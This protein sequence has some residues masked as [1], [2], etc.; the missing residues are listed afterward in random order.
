MF[1]CWC[2]LASQMLNNIT[3]RSPQQACLIHCDAWRDTHGMQVASVPEA[4]RETK[5]IA[6]WVH[7]AGFEIRKDTIWL[8]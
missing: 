3:A 8:K 4:V 7:K 5:M 2:R 1:P 6:N